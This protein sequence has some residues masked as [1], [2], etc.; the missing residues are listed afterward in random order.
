MPPKSST[1]ESIGDILQKFSGPPVD[2]SQPMASG[3][4][5]KVLMTRCGQ[6]TWPDGEAFKSAD[7]KALIKAV[8]KVDGT[9]EL[10]K[11]Q[12][13]WLYEQ[14][15]KVLAGQAHLVR[16]EKELPYI[17]EGAPVAAAPSF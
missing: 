14:F 2:P 7:G 13:D 12:V 5:L 10:R 3:E 16:D 17:R 15:G 8:F 11:P 4:D 1:A 9:K 6:M